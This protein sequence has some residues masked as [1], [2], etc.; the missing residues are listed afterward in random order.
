MPRRSR[1]WKSR[2]KRPL[3]ADAK[4]SIP[5]DH[6]TAE[7]IA[8]QKQLFREKFEREPEPEDPL[9]F[10]PDSAVPAFLSVESQEKTWRALVQAAGESGMDPALVYA[11]NKT[12]RIVTKE[13]MRFL[14]DADIQEWND[15]VDE[16]H[17]V[18]GSGDAQ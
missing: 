15:A 8:Q 3:E 9:F 2:G 10:D 18:I 5:I 16:Y 14:T 1:Q 6:A 12:G 4:R 13:N 11:M 7:A 17:Q